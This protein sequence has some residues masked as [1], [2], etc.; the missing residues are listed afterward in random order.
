M[1]ELPLVG[2]AAGGRLRI[3]TWNMS[4]WRVAK[5]RAVFGEVSADV[6]AIQETHL[7]AVPLH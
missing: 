1:E 3:G 7:A 6:L 5:A 2:S 4:G